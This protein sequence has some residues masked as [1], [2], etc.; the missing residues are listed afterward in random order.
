MPQERRAAVYVRI[1][2]NDDPAK[3]GVGRQAQDCREECERRGWPV[4]DLYEDDDR[5]AYSRR[6]PRPEYERMMA[7]LRAG[8]CD[9]VVVW[10]IDRIY[11]QPRELEDLIDLCEDGRVGF[12]ACSGDYDLSTSEG[13]FM[14]R[15]MVSVANKSS[16]DTSRRQKRKA[17]QVA[18]QGK[19][20]GGPL[21]FGFSADDRNKVDDHEADCIREVTHNLIHGASL[22]SQVR[23]LNERGDHR[24]KLWQES[25]LSRM[26]LRPR[27]IG[28]R[29]HVANGV[30]MTYDAVWDPILTE[31]EHFMLRALLN[32]PARRRNA[33]APPRY[34]LSG[35]LRCGLCGMRMVHAPGW[36]R[37][38]PHYICPQPPRGCNR[39]SVAQEPTD[40]HI[41][42]LAVAVFDTATP[43]TDVEVV[44]SPTPDE[45]APL[46]ERLVMFEDMM[47]TGQMSAASYG[48]MVPKIESELAA[49]EERN[50]DK[51]KAK[52]RTRRAPAT[53]GPVSLREWWPEFSIAK[54]RELIEVVIDHVDVAKSTRTRV[55]DP[56]RLQVTHTELFS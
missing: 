39:V 32:D 3:Q 14:A 54:Q 6:K 38:K 7:D 34:L 21:P 55:F 27:L 25:S 11:R 44:D 23:L 18:E 48:R 19:S 10:D 53:L 28:K 15:M 42:E 52:A 51:I 37:N 26:L 35:L 46:R 13:C 45:A 24:T 5:S 4:H 9:A 17:V 12:A 36:G 8:V 49:L 41:S 20:H 50:A 30:T 47:A 40:Q 22:R 29:E 56:E 33:T 43:L 31:E 1:S 16:K 2:Q